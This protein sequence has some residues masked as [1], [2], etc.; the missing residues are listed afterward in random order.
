MREVVATPTDDMPIQIKHADDVALPRAIDFTGSFSTLGNVLG[1]DRKKYTSAWAHDAKQQYEIKR[2][3]AWDADSPRK[4]PKTDSFKLGTGERGVPN[5][6]KLPSF[7][8]A[9]HSHVRNISLIRESLWNKAEWQGL[10]FVAFPESPPILAVM[11]GKRDPAKE[12]FR[13][14]ENELGK[15]DDKELLRISI[16]RRINRKRPH[17]YRAVLGTNIEHSDLPNSTACVVVMQRIHTMEPASDKNLEMFM[18]A[19]E[20][21]G[22][23]FLAPAVVDRS[24]QFPESIGEFGILKRELIVREAWEIGLDDLDRAGILPGDDPVVP[25]GV[26]DPPVRKVFEAK[27]VESMH[28]KSKRQTQSTSQKEKRKRRKPDRLKAKKSRR[29]K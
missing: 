29:K 13:I 22:A 16:I 9:K 15:N 17:H 12:I 26:A 28:T 18:E 11:F 8:K 21:F 3:R 25:D 24:G 2:S 4:V 20:R 19:Y 23:Y 27:S 7:H 5:E 10:G 1:T 6:T 14:W